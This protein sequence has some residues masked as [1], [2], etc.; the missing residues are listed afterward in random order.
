MIMNKNNQNRLRRPLITLALAAALTLPSFVSARPD[1][2]K[3]KDLPPRQQEWLK[4]ADT[5]ILPA[6]RDVF[7]SIPNER[8]RDVFIEA[9]WKQ[10]DPTPETPANEYKEEMEKRFAY[11][12][13]YYKRGTTRAGW[14]TDQGKIYMILG[15]PKSTNN[16]EGISGLYPAVVWNYYGDPV[17]NLPTFF[18]LIFFQ[19]EGSGEFKLYSPVSD[20]PASLLE[21]T[22][23]LDVTDGEAVFQKMKEVAPD[24]AQTTLSYIPNQYPSY[25]MPSLQNN[26]IIADIYESPKKDI[27]PSYATHFLNYQGIVSTE[28]LTNYIESD[29]AV[30]VHH[31][32]ALDMNLLNFSISPRTVSIDYFKPRDQY[33]CNFKLSVSLR[34][35]DEVVFQYTRDYPFYFPPDRVEYIKANGIAVQDLFPVAEGS[36]KLTVLLQNTV[37][38]EFSLLEKDVN[39]PAGDGPAKITDP[40]IGWGFLDA[41]GT[42]IAPF[43]FLGHQLRTDPK[44]TLCAGDALA[45]AFDLI[46]VPRE[47]WSD[48][49][50]EIEAVGSRAEAKAFSLRTIKLSDLPYAGTMTIADEIAAPGLP[51]DYYELKISLKNGAG[52][53]LDTASSP[54]ILSPDKVVSHAVTLNKALPA[55]NTFLYYY[56]LA[57]QYD[58][59]SQPDKAEAAFQ[60]GRDLKPDYPEGT[61][62]FANFLIREGKADQ[63]LAVIEPLASLANFRFDYFLIKGTAF[64]EQGRFDEAIDSLL[65]G[66]KIYNSDTRLLNA[67]GFCFFKKGMK[68]EAL[69]ALNASLHLDPDQ[70]ETKDLLDRVKKELK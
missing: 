4:L 17:K 66:N 39:V 13:K 26:V 58:K 60:K 44:A 65:E 21:D 28:Y 14:M 27:N 43:K 37:G 59:T 25:F 34:R 61:A 50:V 41:P 48:G 7:L 63:A 20:G 52:A 55:E 57:L 46:R 49:T 56:S 18:S 32:A 22:R 31:D 42:A 2:I 47:I 19:K 51:P 15:P 10:R 69:N 54:L 12:N 11:V 1:K 45:L 29:S 38:K 64:K 67:L 16:Y 33:Y 8:D 68:T 62:Q 36:F 30:S 40:V 9:F 53:V 70:N 6:E 35:A 23:E 3:E 24:L 5:C